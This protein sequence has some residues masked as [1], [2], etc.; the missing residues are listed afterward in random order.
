MSLPRPDELLRHRP[1]ALLLEA[2]DRLEDGRLSCTTTT[3]AR[4]TW[5]DVLESAAQAA[6]LAA[7]L[8]DEGLDNTAVIAEYRH[9]RIH[10]P[11]HA[12]AL[13]V[14]AALERRVLHF[15]RCRVEART[16]DG[17]LLLEATVTLAPGERHDG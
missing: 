7:G 1:P 4:W 13:R 8:L 9:V 15:R 16:L 17:E 11:T 3:R 10:T 6:G 5:P 2:L 14:T 12:G